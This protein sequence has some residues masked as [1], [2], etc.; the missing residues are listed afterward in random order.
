MQDAGGGERGGGEEEE[1]GGGGSDGLSG[2]F[3][4]GLDREREDG[5]E[6]YCAWGFRGQ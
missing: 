1:A 2:G 4:W 6:G 5:R 3:S